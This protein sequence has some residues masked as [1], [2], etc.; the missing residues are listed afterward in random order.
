M[1]CEHG[2]WLARCSL[3][4]WELVMNV[5]EVLMWKADHEENTIK[6]L[7][8]IKIAAPSLSEA[9]KQAVAMSE[10][11]KA[12]GFNIKKIEGVGVRKI[13]KRKA[14]KATPTFPPAAGTRKIKVMNQNG[15]YIFLTKT[16]K[17][18]EK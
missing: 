10:L 6:N 13:I 4:E 14:P 15:K 2:F 18:F 3:F 11:C 12:S 7:L 1:A 9:R 5:Y 8:T 16:R 17:R